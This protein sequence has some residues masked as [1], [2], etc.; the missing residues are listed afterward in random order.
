MKSDYLFELVLNNGNT[1][2]SPNLICR[3]ALRDTFIRHRNV[4][5]SGARLRGLG[6]RISSV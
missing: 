5:V 6:V 1:F 4:R 3:L 2:W